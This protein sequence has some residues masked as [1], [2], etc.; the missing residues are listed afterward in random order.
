MRYPILAVA[1]LALLPS[2]A[3]AQANNKII[4]GTA[5]AATDSGANAVVGGQ[6][7]ETNTDAVGVK[8]YSGANEANE[9]NFDGLPQQPSVSYG[10]HMAVGEE[11]PGTYTFYPVPAFPDYDYIIL[12]GHR[13]IV[14]HKTH[15]IFRVLD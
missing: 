8:T 9:P 10:G 15:K 14:E 7:P 2:L 3:M 1:A 12:N 6:Q 13:V 11:M 5:P 4:G